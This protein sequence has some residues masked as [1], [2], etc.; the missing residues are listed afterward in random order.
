[1]ACVCLAISLAASTRRS[2]PLMPRWTTSRRPPPRAIR[3]NFPRRPTASMRRPV[4]ES[5][6]VS[7]SG[8][9]TMDGNR[10][11]QRTIVRPTRCGR[12]SATI[13]STSGS[14]G[15]KLP[16]HLW[17]GRRA[18]RAGRGGSAPKGHSTS[19]AHHRK[20]S[21]V[22][23]VGPDL[24]LHLDPGVELVRAGHDARHRLGKPA[25]FAFG[26]LEE[27]L[28]VHLQQH[29]ALDVVGLDLPLQA[30][31][32]D[33]DDVGGERL[34]LFAI[35]DDPTNFPKYVPN[36]TGVEDVTSSKGRIG[37]TFRVIYKVLGRSEERR[38]G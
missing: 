12:R 6:K 24:G 31:H 14:S 28:V 37:D 34:Q 21:H 36:V 26:H 5:M 4:I 19:D 8:C 16:P 7:G 11:S 10:S 33:L 15:T 30:H 35:V 9:R 2:W 29:A 23:P 32:R 3:M 18:Q 17:G 13:V 25:H 38:V 22:R 1:M 27:Q 20:L